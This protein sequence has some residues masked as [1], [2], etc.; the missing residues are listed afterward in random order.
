MNDIKI[1]GEV[2][3]VYYWKNGGEKLFVQIEYENAR[4]KKMAKVIT[5]SK[6]ELK[7]IEKKYRIKAKEG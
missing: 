7:E 1:N 3:G 2:V 4:G 5:A 6:D